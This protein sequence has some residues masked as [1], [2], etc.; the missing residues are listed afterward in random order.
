MLRSFGLANHRS[1]DGAQELLLMPAGHADRR[2]VVPVTAIYGANASG[3]SSLLDGLRFMQ[4]AVVQSFT[5][6]DA[7]GGIPRRPFRLRKD[8]AS[9]PTVFRVELVID[10]VPYVYGFSLN[11]DEVL[12]EWLYYYP[13]KRKR[14]LFER[15]GDDIRFGTTVSRDL[16]SKLEI[17]EEMTRPNSLFLSACA[18]VRITEWM[19]VYRW[20][21]SQLR[22]RS[23]TAF[24]NT[25]RIVDQVARMYARNP[26]MLNQML[27]LLVAADVGITGFGISESQDPLQLESLGRIEQ[28][29]ANL[30]ERLA[31]ATTPEESDRLIRSIDRAHEVR[32]LTRRRVAEMRQELKFTHGSGEEFG[33]DEE[34]DGTRSWLAL[35]PMVLEALQAGYVVAV[36]EIDTSLHPLLTAELVKLFRNS[37]TNQNN[38]QLIFTSH[39]S[40]LLGRTTGE[41]IL[42]RESVWFVEKGP[43]GASSLFPLTDFKPRE[44]H[45][46]ERRYLGGSYG[47][48]PVLDSDDFENAVRNR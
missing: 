25:R 33:L 7:E 43:D 6:W 47:A 11:D 36:D 13:E 5:T 28:D 21:R 10:Q 29:I 44:G 16:K 23:S 42:P 2:P 34:S 39:D 3:K 9:E 46:T 38:A 20:F 8:A 24:Y 37:E 4:R 22:M 27:D 35:L 19:P 30:H 31:R 18:Q 48:V 12:E 14:I 32:E 40:S 15:R 26:E 17:L 45:N 1:F 41:E